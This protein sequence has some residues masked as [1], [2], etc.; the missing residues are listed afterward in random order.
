MNGTQAMAA[1]GTL[2]LLRAE[3]LALAADLAGAMTLE[4]LL[5]SHRP[6]APDIQAARGQ[7]G[8][9]ASAAR[10]RE[11]LAGSEINASHQGPDCHKV[12][13]PYSLRCMPQ[14]HGAARDG[15]AFCRRVLA[16]EVNAATDNPLVFA[17]RRARSSRA[18]TST[19]SRWRSRSTCSPSPP[20]TSP[21]SP[22]GASSS[23]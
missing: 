4:G 21:P 10:L 8:Q 9:V 1:V 12:Q 5:G 2:A 17:G 18:A 14:V 3:R 15:L 13:D 20:R 16:R 7:V 23:S 19:A 11:L 22:S 6:F